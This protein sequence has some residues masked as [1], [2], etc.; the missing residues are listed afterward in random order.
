M[1]LS[2][3]TEGFSSDAKILAIGMKRQAFMRIWKSWEFA[4]EREMIF[5]FIKCFLKTD[6]KIVIGFNN[7][8]LD[9]PLLLLRSKELPLFSEFFK[10]L[11]YANVEDLFIILTFINRGVI[12]GLDHYCRKEGIPCEFSDR[13]IISAYISKDY[14][15]FEELFKRKLDAMDGLFLKMWEKV[16]KSG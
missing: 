5:D 10:K 6:D 1:I 3:Q 11:N 4:D 13:D 15:K 2:V 9:I 16:T 8:K 12:K 7:L 14:A